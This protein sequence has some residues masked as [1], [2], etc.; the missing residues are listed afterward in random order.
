MEVIER[1]Y[2]ETVDAAHFRFSRNQ[3]VKTVELDDEMLRDYYFDL[4][5]DGVLVGVEVLNYSEHTDEFGPELD[6][7]NHLP[8]YPGFRLH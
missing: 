7:F 4:D 8:E 5:A 2:D 1:T 3:I 6:V